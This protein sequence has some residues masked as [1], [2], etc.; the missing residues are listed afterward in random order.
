MGKIASSVNSVTLKH[1]LANLCE[2]TA[3]ICLIKAYMGQEK[4]D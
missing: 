2:E 3:P 1:V 4:I